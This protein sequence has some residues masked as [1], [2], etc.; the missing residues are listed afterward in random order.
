MFRI[1]AKLLLGRWALK[2][3]RRSAVCDVHDP[4]YDQMFWSKLPHGPSRQEA[5]RE[6]LK[7][8]SKRNAEL[9]RK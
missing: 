5:I 4:G 8:I 2:T 3:P 9:K 1:R 7:R 6:H